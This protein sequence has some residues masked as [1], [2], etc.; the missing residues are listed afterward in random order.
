[1]RL[2]RII[3]AML[4][5]MASPVAAQSPFGDE[6]VMDEAELADARGGFLLPNGIELEM[7]VSQETSID[8]ELVLRS[9]YVLADGAPVVSIEQLSQ[10]VSVS[11]EE[12][13][14]GNRITIT[15]PGTRVSHLAGRATGSVI[16][17]T[18]DNRQISTITTVDI[19][20]SANAIGQVGSLFPT[21][22]TLAQ[23]AASFSFD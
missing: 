4:A 21:L 20:L 14:T 8:G 9:S 17:N 2:I 13:D 1:M 19:D 11:T 23:E 7:A 15:L 10:N 12:S 18:A 5:M 6:A 3:L 16:E 22:G